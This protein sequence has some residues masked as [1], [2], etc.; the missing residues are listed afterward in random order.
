[1]TTTTGSSAHR[2]GTLGE[3][4]RLPPTD[5]GV[6]NA[7]PETAAV[8]EEWVV[9]LPDATLPR[10]ATREPTTEPPGLDLLVSCAHLRR[11]PG[12]V[13]T[14][15]RSNLRS[16]HEFM[17]LALTSGY[18]P[19]TEP[20]ALRVLREGYRITEPVHLP[21]FFHPP[22]LGLHLERLVDAQ[23]RRLVPLAVNALLDGVL[24]VDD[25]PVRLH[26]AW[27]RALESA[28]RAQQAGLRVPALA[29]G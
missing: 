16:S 8:L 23:A 6:N 13:L 7:L 2:T 17:I 3:A 29:R 27:S 19:W 5:P 14:P 1:M 22:L 26:N 20:R 25:P 10:F 15:Q 21:P 24:G 11:V 4:F 28:A 9:R 12:Q 18:A